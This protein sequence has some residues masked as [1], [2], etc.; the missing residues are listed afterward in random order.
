MNANYSFDPNAPLFSTNDNDEDIFDFFFNDLKQ[1][2]QPLYPPD[3]G[4]SLLK[5]EPP[6]FPQ[7]DNTL[8]N[9]G[10]GPT[11]LDNF[12]NT[13]FFSA[14]FNDLP[15][16]IPPSGNSQ[17]Y[18]QRSAIDNRQTDK[19]FM[20][21][22]VATRPEMKPS[23]SKAEQVREKN[24]QAVRDCRKRKREHALLLNAKIETLKLQNANLRRKILLGTKEMP[25]D[26]DDKFE[27]DPANS[28]ISLLNQ[29]IKEC[30]DKEGIILSEVEESLFYLFS[31]LNQFALPYNVTKFYLWQTAQ[32]DDFFKNSTNS[33][34]NEIS[35]HVNI[36]EEQQNKLTQRRHKARLVVDAIN[37]T[38]QKINSVA[39]LLRKKNSLAKLTE[40]TQKCLRSSL[41]SAEIAKFLTKAKSLDAKEVGDLFSR[42]LKEETKKL[43][44]INM[45]AISLNST[46]MESSFLPLMPKLQM[47]QEHN[48]KPEEVSKTLAERRKSSALVIQEIF[49]GQQNCVT[50]SHATYQSVLNLISRCF[51]S[52]ASL[53]DPNFRRPISNHDGLCLFFIKFKRAFSRLE[54]KLK[55]YQANGVNTAKSTWVVTATHSNRSVNFDL[56]VQYK[57]QP[58]DSMINQIVFSWAALQLIQKLGLLANET[59]KPIL[60]LSSS[61]KELEKTN[62]A[63]SDVSLKTKVQSFQDS[64]ANFMRLFECKSGKERRLWV[65]KHD[66]FQEGVSC[67][68]SNIGGCFNGVEGVL[69]YV[70]KL[71]KAFRD[72]EVSSFNF[73]PVKGL[74]Y[75]KKNGIVKVQMGCIVSG[76]Y[77]GRL[78]YKTGET[79]F[80]FPSECFF[81][82]DEN[83]RIVEV[84]L[85]MDAT[86]L[87][88]KIGVVDARS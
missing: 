65:K 16:F 54:T 51:T 74:G 79:R 17:T 31:R 60:G 53:V 34:W 77:H 39:L 4:D 72:I 87:L 78:G 28:E 59:I 63:S 83:G 67:M 23:L 45:D 86:S 15:E 66:L 76:A 32:K 80:K 75:S 56:V 55:Q 25:I 44:A 5:I 69:S 8:P 43:P 49:Q 70:E 62:L 41:S 88:Q 20:P 11:S 38:V 37:S 24:R 50:S 19:F 61:L 27:V 73:L 10:A 58:D 33:L 85:N 81:V 47:S 26:G 35:S 40:L 2:Q 18:Q 30:F 36:T 12:D 9:P 13:S 42:F 68:D 64:C 52:D 1:P 57:F 7:L 82:F 3:P 46:P 48:N 14:V 71:T 84:V 6:N 29:K 22:S 21:S